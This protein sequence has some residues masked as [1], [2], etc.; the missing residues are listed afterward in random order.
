MNQ[1]VYEELKRIATEKAVTNYTAVGL[2][3]DLDMGNPVDRNEITD[4]LDEIN[5]YE[6]QHG[7]PMLSAVVIRQDINTPGDGF[8]KCAKRLGIYW[9]S[10]DLVFWVYEVTKVHNHWQ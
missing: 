5:F 3:I 8:F 4:V 7:R 6:H 9:G 10:D 1:V 2:L